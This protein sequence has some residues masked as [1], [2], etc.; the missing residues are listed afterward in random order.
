M[1]R[2]YGKSASLVTVAPLKLTAGPPV[3][4][5]FNT[6]TYKTVYAARRIERRTSQRQ[7]CYG[8]LSESDEQMQMQAK[9]NDTVYDRGE[10][11]VTT[12]RIWNRVIYFGTVY[13]PRT[14][15]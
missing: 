12:T 14:K 15:P 2:P 10:K 8:V 7:M 5:A 13:G 1:F 4:N 3:R 9:D 6:I 11:P